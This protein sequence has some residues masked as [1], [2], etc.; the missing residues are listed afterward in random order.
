MRR[1]IREQSIDERRLAGACLAIPG[2]LD[3]ISGAPDSP[4]WLPG[5]SAVPLGEVLGGH[6]EM[7]VPVV[8]DTLAAVIGENWVR[9]GET[10]DSTMIFV[11]VGTGTGLGL[12]I[13]G[14]PVRGFSGNSG[15]VGTMMTALGSRTPGRHTGMDNDPAFIVERAH[16]LGLQPEPLPQRTDYDAVEWR[17]ER[18]CAAATQGDGA[19]MSFCAQRPRVWQNW[20]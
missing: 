3:P 11:Y 6:L 4:A 14:E 12:S 17:L 10:L 18:L 2:P 15:E 13:N 5:W 1:L 7:S 20:S 8:K 9:G 19:R 16:G